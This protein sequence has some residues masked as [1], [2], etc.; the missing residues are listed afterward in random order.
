MAYGGTVSIGVHMDVRKNEIVF[1]F[2]S[3][4]AQS[5]KSGKVKKVDRLLQTGPA[6][7]GPARDEDQVCGPGGQ[8]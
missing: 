8:K 4:L 1:Y 6:W 2:F 3:S 7:P 5:E